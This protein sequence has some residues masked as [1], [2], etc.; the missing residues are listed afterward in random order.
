MKWGV[1]VGLL[2]A[3]GAMYVVIRRQGLG[4]AIPGGEA[5]NLNP[6][7]YNPRELRVG[8]AI[9]MEHTTSRRVARE[10]AMDHLTEDPR[11]Y[12]N[13]CRWHRDAACK[14]L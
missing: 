11:Y 6:R 8:T 10:I 1:I 2:V 5:R 7:A 3:A 14:K 9:E 13:L 4:E 12:T